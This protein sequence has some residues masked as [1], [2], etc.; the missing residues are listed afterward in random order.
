MGG[1]GCPLR[2]CANQKGARH[3][4]PGGLREIC[5]TCPTLPPPLPG[6]AQAGLAAISASALGEAWADETP[7]PVFLPRGASRAGIWRKG[8]G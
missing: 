7:M 4:R 3:A 2:H 6:T 8:E 5:G 1:V